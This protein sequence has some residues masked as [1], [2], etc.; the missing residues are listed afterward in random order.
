[1]GAIHLRVLTIICLYQ[2]KSAIHITLYM[3]TE[4]IDSGNTLIPLL[5]RPPYVLRTPSH[6]LYNDI[7]GKRMSL[8]DYATSNLSGE[9]RNNYVSRFLQLPAKE[10]ERDPDKSIMGAYNIL[11]DDYSV[12]GTLDNLNSAMHSLARI[13]TFRNEFKVTKLNETV[14]RPRLMEI[15]QI[16]LNTIAEVNHLDVSLFELVKTNLAKN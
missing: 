14:D 6:Y 4:L 8:I 7:V 1:M 2:K 13:A 5:K 15:D 3:A 11:K 16:T 12:V 10:A 9:L